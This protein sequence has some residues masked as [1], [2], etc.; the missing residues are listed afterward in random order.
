LPFLCFCSTFTD[1]KLVID[2][3]TYLNTEGRW[4]D[5]FNKMKVGGASRLPA[6]ALRLAS[7]CTW[8][9]LARPCLPCNAALNMPD[10]PCCACCCA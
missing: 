8:H 2:N 9:C 5:L 7:H 4:R 1:L 6:L 3:R 10:L